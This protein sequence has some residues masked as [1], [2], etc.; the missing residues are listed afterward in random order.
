MI[1]F[2]LV[3]TVIVTVVI[4]L[5]IHILIKA[6]LNL[7]SILFLSHLIS[8]LP[9]SASLAELVVFVPLSTSLSLT[10]LYVSALRPNVN[11]V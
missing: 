7:I 3:V 1:I 8:L 11:V 6:M 10:K 4:I 2:T 9:A 5:T